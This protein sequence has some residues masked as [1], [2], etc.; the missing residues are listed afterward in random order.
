MYVHGWNQ[1]DTLMT[2]ELCNYGSYK[3]VFLI[4]QQQWEHYEKHRGMVNCNGEIPR[5]K[6][7]KY[8]SNYV[9]TIDTIDTVVI[10]WWFDSKA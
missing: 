4:R 8:K 6:T 3:H 10:S 9:R 5:Y 1:F 7:I 2:I